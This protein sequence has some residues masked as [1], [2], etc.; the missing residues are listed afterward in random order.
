MRIIAVFLYVFLFGN[1]GYAQVMS[2]QMDDFQNGTVQGWI[3]GNGNPSGFGTSVVSNAG[4]NGMGDYALDYSSTGGGGISSRMVV[5]NQTL[6]WQGNYLQQDIELIRFDVKAEVNNLNLKIAFQRGTNDNFT[7]IATIDPIVVDAGTGWTSVEIPLAIDNFE[8]VDNY[9]GNY[10]ISEVLENVSVMRIL[11]ST[12]SLWLGES[13]AANMQLDNITATTSLSTNTFKTN[14]VFEILPNPASSK[15]T[16]AL[17]EGITK[18]KAVVY[19]VLGKKIHEKELH[20][21]K[22][23]ID[24][25]NWN[26]GVYLVR[27]ITDNKTL[28][29]R[30][31]KQ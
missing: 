13:I 12:S 10:S 24:I 14:N 21:G 20:T 11:S 30:F 23:Q 8:I 17:N 27:I 4:P 16:I 28:T 29:K 22:T 26:T 6:K 9:L 7:R 2:G 15:M 18:S 19:D 5:F 31:V 3:I 25:S 1:M